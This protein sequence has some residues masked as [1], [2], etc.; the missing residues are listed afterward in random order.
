MR[1][2]EGSSLEQNNV[3]CIVTEFKCQYIRGFGGKFL[4]C[5]DETCL[6]YR[7]GFKLALNT[8]TSISELAFSCIAS[9]LRKLVSVTMLCNVKYSSAVFVV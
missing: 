7:W 9:R 4:V 3:Y 2:L 5:K 8:M 1:P 6:D